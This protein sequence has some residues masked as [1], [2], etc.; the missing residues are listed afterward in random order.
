MLVGERKIRQ[1][2]AIRDQVLSVN[3]ILVFVQEH[4]SESVVFQ[5]AFQTLKDQDI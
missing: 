2:C 3:A 1:G 5:V 4:I